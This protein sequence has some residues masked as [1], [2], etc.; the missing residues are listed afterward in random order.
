MTDYQV[1]SEGFEPL[2]DDTARIPRRLVEFEWALLCDTGYQPQL[3]RDAATGA[4]LPEGTP[5][6]AFSPGA[7]GVVADTGETDRW[8]V[9]RE[10][11]ELIR[12]VAAG[13]VAGTPSPELCDRAARLLATY[14][15]ELLGVEPKAMRWAFP[16]L[17]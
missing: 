8:R 4:P 14:I 10:T 12:A 16:D 13:T 17:R 9:R 6:L 7:G 5:T 3:D 11:I 15:R 1:N 2:L